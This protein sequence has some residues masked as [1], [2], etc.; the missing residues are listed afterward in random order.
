M[1]TNCVNLVTN[2]LFIFVAC[3]IYFGLNVLIIKLSQVEILVGLIIPTYST[4]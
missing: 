2:E 1:K 4:T 3:I